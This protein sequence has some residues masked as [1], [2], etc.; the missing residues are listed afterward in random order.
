MAEDDSGRVANSHKLGEM[1]GKGIHAQPT[2]PSRSHSYGNSALHRERGH[3]LAVESCASASESDRATDRD[4]QRPTSSRRP[5]NSSNGTR[6]RNPAFLLAPWLGTL[7][8]GRPRTRR[9]R[10]SVL[11]LGQSQDGRVHN[12]RRAAV[13]GRSP[14]TIGWV[15]DVL[16]HRADGSRPL[17]SP[18]LGLPGATV[19]L[20]RPAAC[21][22]AARLG[23]R[24]RQH[25][26][27]TYR[28]GAVEAVPASS[29]RWRRRNFPELG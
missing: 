21:V 4:L 29:W 9:S 27:S 1:I 3:A 7:R 23:L 16:R 26:W 6:V 17:N 14:P 28:R 24:S 11:R 18:W 15:D 19:V 12:V 13:G 20:R 5:G 2:L 8:Q 10:V 22:I 25:L